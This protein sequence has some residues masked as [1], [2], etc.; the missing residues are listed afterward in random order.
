MEQKSLYL[1]VVPIPNI[2]LLPMHLTLKEGEAGAVTCLSRDDEYGNF[3]YSW[4]Y[5]G[6]PLTKGPN[7]EQIEKVVPIGSRLTMKKVTRS[8][9]YTCVVQSLA[10]SVSKSI[11]VSILKGKVSG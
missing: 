7:G 5:E 4:W 6:N 9:N 3:T 2:D 10:G 11:F 8:A 1:Y